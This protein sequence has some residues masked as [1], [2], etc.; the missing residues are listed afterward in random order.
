MD[1]QAFLRATADLIETGWCRGADARDCQGHAV[2]AC[3]PSAAAWSL[4]GA[5]FV[6]SERGDA[7]RASLRDAL[8][9]ISGVIPDASLEGWNDAD[10][11][12]R[13][14]TLRMLAHAQTRLDE[15]PPPRNGWT[16]R[17]R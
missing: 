13:A 7:D 16:T 11:R 14:Q 9:A 1:G 17:F 4:V 2:E 6:V 8:W 15:G 5:L 10:G 3:D 12:T